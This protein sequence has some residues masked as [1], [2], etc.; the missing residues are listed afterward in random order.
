[1]EELL[2]FYKKHQAIIVPSLFLLGSVF[3]LIQVIFPTLSAI[4]SLQSQMKD[5]QKKLSD[6]TNS[7]AVLNSL[8]G[9]QIN[10]EAS[11]ATTAL[12]PSKDVQSI[13][14]AITSSAAKAG[15]TLSGF[16]VSLGDVFGQSN[17]VQPAKGIP[18]V[19]VTVKLAGV[20]I[21]SLVQFS[22]ELSNTNPLSKVIS[23]SINAGSG[24]VN[25]LFY[26]K[27]YDLTRINKDVVKPLTPS[28]LKI[29]NALPQP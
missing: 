21:D 22:S 26:Y 18:Y 4:G 28:E 13:Y 11:I 9:S 12:P 27:P 24:D 25:I 5:E 7:I 23:A 17:V 1:M 6:Y 20:N 3:I 8:D 2:D 16:T 29:L 14:L 15:V 10:Q 19:I